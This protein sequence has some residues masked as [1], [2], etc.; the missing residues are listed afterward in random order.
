MAY[1]S[2][3][4]SCQATWKRSNGRIESETIE[5]T[6]DAHTEHEAK[7]LAGCALKRHHDRLDRRLMAYSIHIKTKGK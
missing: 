2:Y 5:L 1:N 4:C 7:L 3:P 6:I